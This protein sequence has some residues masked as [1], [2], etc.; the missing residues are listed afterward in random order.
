MKSTSLDQFL[1]E[2]KAALA[3]GPLAMIFAEDPVE[4]DTTLRHHI[5]AG[6]AQVLL[7]APDA[8]NLPADL[9]AKI[10]RVTHDVHA[11]DCLLY[12]S[13]CV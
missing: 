11:E 2:A 6:F 5:A 9:E 3:V 1:S 8:I 12:T 4:V 13:R 7:L 10:H